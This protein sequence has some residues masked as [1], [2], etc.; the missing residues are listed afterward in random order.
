MNL[1]RSNRAMR[2]RRIG[3]A[4]GVLAVSS[5][6]LAGCASGGDAPSSDKVELTFFNQSRGQE[7]ALT[8][9][10]EQYTKETGVTITVETPG[11]TDYLPK[12]QAKAQS[13]SMPD[14][15]SSFDAT[16]MA[17][18]YKAGWA[19]DLTKE[20]DAGWKK[21]FSPAILE[22]SKFSKGNNLGVPAGTY[23]VHWETQTYGILAD[24]S[25][26]GI[27]AANP[28]KTTDD[29]IAD[30]TKATAS[31]GHGAFT[32]AASLTPRLIQTYASN[33][34]TDDEISATFDGKKSWKSDGWKKAFQLL[35]DL[36][37]AG[38]LANDSLPGGQDDNPSVEASFFNKQEVGAIFDASPGVSVGFRTAPDYSSYISLA[39]PAAPDAKHESRSAGV[40]GKGAVINPKGKHPEEALKFV[41]WLTAADQQK[42]FAEDARIIPTNPELLASGTLPEQLA[43]FGSAVASMQVL[44]NTLA[45]D[46]ATAMVKDA[47]S[48]VLGE[49]TVDQVLDDLQATQERIK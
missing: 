45:T 4:A 30:F 8:K 39:L 7:T 28:P 26:S 13:K 2:R 22:L 44:P 37:K 18:F 10:A 34:L 9:L 27:D 49:M 32:I 5:L 11:P 12:L 14:I 3:L 19:M 17:P 33:W 35:V 36:K 20:L 41:K 42:V 25:T 23:T 38:V 15:Y 16:N 46:V 43:G 21:D 40:P 1:N 47:Q 48:L 24:T 6:L 31:S 29:L